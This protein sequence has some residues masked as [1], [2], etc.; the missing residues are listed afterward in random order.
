MY[1]IYKRWHRSDLKFS[2]KNAS[3]L[4]AI[5]KMIFFYT[6]IFSSKFCNLNAQI[7]WIFVGLPWMFSENGKQYGEFSAKFCRNR[8]NYL[9]TYAILLFNSLLRRS[10]GGPCSSTR[11]RTATRTRT[12]TSGTSSATR[13]CGPPGLGRKKKLSARDPPQTF[14]QS[15]QISWKLNSANVDFVES[16]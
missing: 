5:S 7:W 6:F 2:A 16:R 1:K 9:L 10:P 3:S 12:R 14:C 15:W 13:R 11:T 8:I 4:Y